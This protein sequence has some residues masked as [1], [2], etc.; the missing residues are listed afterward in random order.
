MILTFLRSSSIGAY[1]MCPMQYYLSYVLKEPSLP[2]KAAVLGNV[3]HKALEALAWVSYWDARGVAEF[4]EE[5]FGRVTV[6]EMTPEECCHRAYLHYR[7]LE[8]TIRWKDS[9]DKTAEIDRQNWRRKWEQ[10]IHIPLHITKKEL[11]ERTS[12]FSDYAKTQL[13]TQRAL[14]WEGGAFDP[15]NQVVI[16]AEQKF[17]FTLDEEWAAYRYETPEGVFEGQLGLKGTMDLVV[18]E[19]DN[20]IHLCDYKTGSRKDWGEDDEAKAFKSYKKLI[21]EA[22]LLLYFFATCRLFPAAKMVLVTIFYI[23]DGGPVTIAYSERDIS[24][25]KAM[26][27]RVFEE[28]R[29]C[30]IP[31]AKVGKPCFTFCSYGKRSAKNRGDETTCDRFRREVRAKG[32]DQLLYEVGSVAS[33]SLYG[34]GGGRQAESEKTPSSQG[35]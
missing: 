28:I 30:R 16:Q 20:C 21:D 11:D 35:D 34:S 19:G 1:K 23:N 27:R 31:L 9:G 14:A 12:S 17:D 32:A 2:S 3:V 10:G 22:Q 4:D 13:W 8:P 29:D 33:V 6:A 26:F 18:D 24:R 7:E 25:A 15:R 5:T